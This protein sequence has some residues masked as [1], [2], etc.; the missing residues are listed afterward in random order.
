[1][2]SISKFK[3][4]N[5]SILIACRALDEGFDVPA[6]ETGIILAGTSSVR[7]WIQRMGRILRKSPL[8]EHSKI[9]VVFVDMIEQDIFTAKDLADFEKE[10]ISIELI[11]LS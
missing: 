5:I 6:A 11:R 2:A 10:A 4:G 1:M 7:Q 8:K 9:Y 3:D